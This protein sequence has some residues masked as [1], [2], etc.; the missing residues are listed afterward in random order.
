MI[1]VIEDDQMINKL[2]CKVLSDSGYETDSAADGNE[3]LSKALAN[4]YELIR[5]D[6]MLPGRTGAGPRHGPSAARWD[7]TR[8][9][10]WYRATGWSVPAAA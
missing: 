5:L 3:G 8:F 2:L 6:L 9:R 7:E 10:S 4:E 1:L